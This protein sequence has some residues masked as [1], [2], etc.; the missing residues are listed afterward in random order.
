MLF[1]NLTFVFFCFSAIPESTWKAIID[2]NMTLE[3]NDKQVIS[4]RVIAYDGSA[5]TICR[6]DGYCYFTLGE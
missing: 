2:K 6:N 3:T 1:I 5:V 4:C